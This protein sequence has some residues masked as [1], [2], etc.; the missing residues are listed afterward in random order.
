MG[1]GRRTD[2]AKLV[3]RL[4]GSAE[5]KARLK[6]IL[7]MLGAGR[8]AGE[9]GLTVGVSE[10]RLHS[11]RRRALQHA[12]NSLEFQPVG[13]RTQQPSQHDVEIAALHAEVTRLRIDLRAAQIR[14]E[15]AL[16]IPQLLKRKRRTKKMLRP[17]LSRHKR[18]AKPGT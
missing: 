13:R 1:R 2:C 12:L 4:N 16:A 3:D 11:L 9:A 18:V 8:T 5:A 17:T 10:R 14:E 6:V 7:Q 15:I